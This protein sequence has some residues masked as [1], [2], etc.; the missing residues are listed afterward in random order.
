MNGLTVWNLK[1]GEGDGERRMEADEE[2]RQ[3]SMQ[4]SAGPSVLVE[5]IE[6]EQRH[7]VCAGGSR[8]VHLCLMCLFVVC[9]DLSGVVNGHD[10]TELNAQILTNDAIHTN[11][12][13][14]TR[15]H[16]SR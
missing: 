14:K 10:V 7:R 1:E 13:N 5:R 6:V 12:T 9:F 4:Q 16:K 8:I 2:Q 11:L 15:A 3:S